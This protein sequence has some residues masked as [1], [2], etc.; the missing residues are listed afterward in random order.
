MP[1]NPLTLTRQ[2]FYELVWSKPMATLAQEFGITDVGL[3]KRCC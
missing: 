2:T 1:L 3:A